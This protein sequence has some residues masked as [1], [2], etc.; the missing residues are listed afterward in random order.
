MTAHAIRE[1][2]VARRVP[3]TGVVAIGALA[4]IVIG[5]AMASHTV[6]EASVVEAILSPINGIVAVGTLTGIMIG[7]GLAAVALDTIIRSGVIKLNNVTPVAGAVAVGALVVVV[8][9]WQCM[10][11]LAIREASMVKGHIFPIGDV[12]AV[13]ALP[14]VVIIRSVF[15]MTRLAISPASVI[16]SDIFPIGDTGVTVHTRA[17]IQIFNK[18]IRAARLAHHALWEAREIPQITVCL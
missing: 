14:I 9:C 2:A 6:G 7:R 17:E 13:R 10:A 4:R 8:I 15:H 5:R 12:V 18:R 3:T 1:A 11:R 16:K